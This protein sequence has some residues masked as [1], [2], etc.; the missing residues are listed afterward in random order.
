MNAFLSLYCVN[1]GFY[2]KERK[3]FEDVTKLDVEENV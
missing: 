2:V 3:L 1:L